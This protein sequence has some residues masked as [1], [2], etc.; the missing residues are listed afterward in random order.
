[1]SQDR[2]PQASTDETHEATAPTFATLGLEPTLFYDNAA[3][4]GRRWSQMPTLEE[5]QHALGLIFRYGEVLQ[6]QDIDGGVAV[7]LEALL[8]AL[9]KAEAA[10][11]RCQQA[12]LQSTQQLEAEMAG[13]TDAV[14]ATKNRCARALRKSQPTA[15]GGFPKMVGMR[16]GVKACVKGTQSAEAFVSTWSADLRAAKVDVNALARDLSRHVE[17]V[18][19]A[20]T[21]QERAKAQAEQAAA[22]TQSIRGQIYLVAGEVYRAGRTAFRTQPEIK[23]EFKY[24]RLVQTPAPAA[25]TPAVEA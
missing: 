3:K 9:P 8:A 16:T 20:N 17:A 19:S 10:S 7:T 18:T 11:A 13:A 23:A 15:M 5:G 22:L 2:R 25:P 24:Q 4:A 21:A 14:S 12:Q 6:A 1:M